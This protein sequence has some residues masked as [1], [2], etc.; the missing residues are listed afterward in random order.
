MKYSKIPNWEDL[1]KR[2]NA[3]WDENLKSNG[4]IAHIQNPSP[5]EAQREPENWMIEASESKYLDP[6][7]LYKMKAWRQ[8]FWNWHADLFQYGMPSY[9]PNTFI[10]F[11]GG[12]VEFGKDTTWHE[13]SIN[14]TDEFYKINFDT[15]NRYWK[16]LLESIEYHIEYLSQEEQLAMPD[17]GG[18][19]DWI[20]SLLGTE[21]F[22][23]ACIDEPDKIRDFALRLAEESNIAFNIVY[24]IMKE[25]N[26]G[27]SN[28]MPVWSPFK[29]PTLQDDVA[30]N[31][32]PEM[33]AEIFLPAQRAIL[34]NGEKN[35]LHWHDASAHHIKWISREKKIDMVQFGHDPNTGNFRKQIEYMKTLQA[36]GKKL[37]ISCVEANDVEFFINNLDPMALMMIINTESDAESEI[38]ESNVKKWTERRLEKI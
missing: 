20:S 38:M 32:S 10:G 3:F 35:V 11:C 1:K 28:W 6:E 21:N 8:S 2:Y 14:S 37:F 12:R 22:L 16:A 31:I 34:S 26:D 9:G 15:E 33:Y 25:K 29:M 4:I 17:F 19:A 24:G 30:V 36:S 7:K 27:C 5:P 23:L 13:P 18:P